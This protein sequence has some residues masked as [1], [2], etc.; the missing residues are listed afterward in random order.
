MSPELTL[1]LLNF[2][3][4]F[5]AYV[6]VYPRLQDKSLANISKQDLLVTAVSLIVSGSLY[7]AKDVEFSLVF[8]EANWVVFTII[9]F[10]LI[11]LPFALWFKRRYKI[12]FKD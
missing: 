6:I 11:E 2:V 9:V 7:Y 5:V 1:I 4:L 3:L 12:K 8:F 10:S